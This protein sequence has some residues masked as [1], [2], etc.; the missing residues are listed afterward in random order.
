MTP[1][2]FF[3]ITVNLVL[4]I[5]AGAVM[6][7]ADF[8][9]AGT[10]RDFFLFRKT[11]M[12]RALLLLIVTTMVL[13]EILR[14]LGLLPLYPFPLLGSPS[15]ANIAGGILFGTGMV[16][17]GGCVV[18]TLYKMGGGSIISAAAFIGLIVGSGLYAEIHPWWSGIVKQFTFFKG[19]LTLPQVIGCSPVLIIIPLVLVCGF[20]FYR[21]QR[22]KKW[23]RTSFVEGYLQPWKAAL[24]LALFGTLS[25]L[26]VGMPFGITTAYAKAAA[27]FTKIVAPSHVA[28]TAFYN[29]VPLHYSAPI[30]HVQLLGGAGPV[31]D[32]ITYIQ[33]PLIA[34][35]IL[36]A[37]IAAL[38]V[39]E[40]KIY[41]RVPARQYVSAL[42]GG[43]ILALGSRMTPGCNV[44][45]LFGGLP[46]LNMQSLLFLI[47]IIPG[48]YIGT[49][50]LVHFVLSAGAKAA[51]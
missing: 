4:G 20:F 26:L 35:I 33:F 49:K 48:S 51:T 8:C 44:W 37:M 32:A 11:I 15:L 46:I 50:I 31:V 23:H 1:A 42:V 22:Q 39:G 41:Y 24:Y 3:I 30:S 16:T 5:I 9:V 10:F 29:A 7:R 21:W 47:G 25:Y 14:Q 28:Q 40:F 2:I 18:G 38:R 6:Y 13:V 34:G 17:A 27:Y 19:H 36:G 12:L 45:H 43:I